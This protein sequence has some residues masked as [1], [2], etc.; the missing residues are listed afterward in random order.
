MPVPAPGKPSAVQ[1][2]RHGGWWI[3]TLPCATAN[4][5]DAWMFQ[6]DGSAA[7]G[8]G[9]AF[10]AMDIIDQDRSATGLFQSFSTLRKSSA[11]PF[12]AKRTARTELGDATGLRR[13]DE[14]FL[15]QA[16][17]RHSGW[18]CQKCAIRN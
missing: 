10:V 16:L 1:D 15:N 3:G 18:I 7:G 5:W 17:L 4:G 9:V 6:T 8:R 2:A 14:P 12:D 11:R 13:G